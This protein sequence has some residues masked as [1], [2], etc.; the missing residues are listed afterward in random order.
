MK[1]EKDKKTGKWLIDEYAEVEDL[2]NVSVCYAGIMKAL[3]G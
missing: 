3:L 2:I 1:A